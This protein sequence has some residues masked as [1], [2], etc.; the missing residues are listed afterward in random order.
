SLSGTALI[1]WF[2][3]DRVKA[4]V[5]W[6]ETSTERHIL[7]F[8]ATLAANCALCY[9]YTKDEILTT[10]GALYAVAAYGAVRHLLDRVD[11]QPPFRFRTAALGVLLL[12]GSVAWSIRAVGVHHVLMEQGFRYRNDWARLPVIR[13][14]GM[15]PRTAEG[16]ELART[17]REQTLTMR[18]VNPHFAPRSAPGIFGAD[19]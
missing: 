15:T 19:Y 5:R 1:G 18:Q 9:S 12:T 10:A 2:L 4:G 8:V 6:P 11:A 13:D 14:A 7:V 3:V 16:I 17:L